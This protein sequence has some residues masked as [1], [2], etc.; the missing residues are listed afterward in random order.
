M[1][2]L[3]ASPRLLPATVALGLLLVAAC[4][5]SSPTPSR[6]P[7]DQA[8]LQAERDKA[9]AA[10]DAAREAERLKDLWTYAAV[11]A[12]KGQQRTAAINS[13]ED[14]DTGGDGPHA[15]MLVFRD[16]PAWG[17]SSY[18]ILKTGDFRCTPT[19]TVAVTA[20]AA[21]TRAIK[22][23]RPDTKEA[24]AL[25]I[26]DWKSLWRTTA[27]AARLTI[28][29]PVKAGGTRTA[30]FDVGGLDAARLPNWSPEPSGP[31]S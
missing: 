11:P 8:A 21:P 27:D 3:R 19:C 24:I 13:T 7:A 15:V 23:H 4:G 14:V 29:F 9:R 16:H 2:V 6:S 17:R 18:L 5:P 22:A 25:F 31:S 10:A 30:T 28:T 12:G 1:P 20:D 26:D